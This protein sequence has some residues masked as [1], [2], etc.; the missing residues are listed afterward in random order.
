MVVSMQS[1]ALRGSAIQN[2]NSAKGDA[3]TQEKS[4]S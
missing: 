3:N 2:G 1:T 4:K